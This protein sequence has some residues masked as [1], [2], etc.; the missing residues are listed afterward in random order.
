VANLRKH[1]ILQPS[2]RL[3]RVQAL[4]RVRF[5]FLILVHLLARDQLA[6]APNSAA[7]HPSGACVLQLCMCLI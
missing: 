1:Q 6:Q 5:Y 2:I 7:K 4:L 3:V